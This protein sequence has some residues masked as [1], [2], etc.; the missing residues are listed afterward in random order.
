MKAHFTKNNQGVNIWE[1]WRMRT[2][3]PCVELRLELHL[4]RSKFQSLEAVQ[5][6]NYSKAPPPHS[7][8]TN[9]FCGSQPEACNSFPSWRAILLCTAEIPFDSAHHPW[10]HN[11]KN[12]RTIFLILLPFPQRHSG[13]LATICQVWLLPCHSDFHLKNSIH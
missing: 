4:H 7:L 2:S 10:P 1:H 3:Q 8:I 13:S 6:Q 9:C 5:G 11:K 12:L